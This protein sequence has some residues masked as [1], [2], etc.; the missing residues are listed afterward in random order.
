[1]LLYAPLGL[2]LLAFVRPSAVFAVR[3][4]GN[5]GA[6]SGFGPRLRA[7]LA[8]RPFRA[9]AFAARFGFGLRRS[10]LPFRPGLR[11]T[12]HAARAPGPLPSPLRHQTP[13]HRRDAR[14]SGS[15]A[16]A[17]CRCMCS[18]EWPETIVSLKDCELLRPHAASRRC[19]PP[20]ATR[21]ASPLPPWA[22]RHQAVTHV[23]GPRSSH[24]VSLSP[25]ILSLQ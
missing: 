22:G 4:S 3:F 19:R 18:G 24:K 25:A 1:M 8:T 11:V 16:R 12:R 5:P 23:Q 9:S 13:P 20:L 2:F 10:P 6:G 7:T 21:R 14:S 15:E 17:R